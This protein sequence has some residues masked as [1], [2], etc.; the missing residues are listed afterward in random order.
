MG[1]YSTPAAANRAALHRFGLSLLS[2]DFVNV[3]VE[4][5]GAQVICDEKGAHGLLQLQMAHDEE[6]S[7]TLTV[8]VTEHPL[9]GG[10]PPMSQ[11][12]YD[13]RL[14][15]LRR[16]GAAH[17]DARWKAEVDDDEERQSPRSDSE[18]GDGER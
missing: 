3:D 4:D 7:Y 6:C 5:E 11:K 13:D 18:D 10:Q 9:D 16:R 15:A 8:R 1:V 2:D 12:V 14:A 17:E